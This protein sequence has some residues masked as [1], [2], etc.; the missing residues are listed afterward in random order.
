MSLGL[1]PE[2]DSNQHAKLQRL[3]RIFIFCK[4]KKVEVF[5]C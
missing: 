5:Y 3:A 1:L 4:L 2:L